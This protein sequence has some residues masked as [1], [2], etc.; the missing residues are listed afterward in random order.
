M[1]FNC[2]NQFGAV[3]FC[4]TLI[5]V[6]LLRCGAGAWAQSVTQ[7]QLHLLNET[8]SLAWDHS[9][10]VTEYEVS[11]KGDLVRGR[12]LVAISYVEQLKRKVFAV[13]LIGSWAFVEYPDG[14]PA[15]LAA[16]QI[17]SG[18][19]PLSYIFNPG[20]K[21]L[22]TF[23]HGFSEA[24]TGR[25]CSLWFFIDTP[26]TLNSTGGVASRGNDSM[27][28]ICTGA[29]G[30]F[31]DT[32]NRWSDIVGVRWDG[33]QIGDN[34]PAPLILQHDPKDITAGVPGA[35]PLSLAPTPTQWKSIPL[36]A[37]DV[38]GANEQY[39]VLR[40]RNGPDRTTLMVWNRVTHQWSSIGRPA[41]RFAYRIFGPWLTAN[42]L[43]CETPEDSLDET[44][45]PQAQSLID[46]RTGRT[47][48][49]EA[50]KDSEIILLSA[51][52][53]GLLRE[54][55]TLYSFTAGAPAST[56]AKVAQSEIITHV[57]WAWY[58]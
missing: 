58:R 45:V 14:I 19:G 25:A 39:L 27:R 13:H 32:R 50:G 12:V 38:A 57:H 46:L 42:A 23:V 31:Q 43:T 55:E 33:G 47:L 4:S 49:V 16:Y 26:P 44:C 37:A 34:Y 5:A 20:E 54:G 21:A 15:T 3:R 8:Q 28:S 18:T 9:S 51:E 41:G 30:E 6:L 10:S 56:R 11:T 52:G 22:L 7:P 29:D 17:S 24:Q 40:D 36:G 48:P 2:L 53:K 1:S 35:P